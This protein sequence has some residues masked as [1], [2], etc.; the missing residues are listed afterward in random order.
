MRYI[1]VLGL[2]FSLSFVSAIVQGSAAEPLS[3]DTPV[4]TAAGAT[5]TAPA[6]CSITSSANKNVLDPPEAD[7]PARMDV[8]YSVVPI[9]RAGGMWT[10]PRDLPK[11]KQME[12]AL[13]QL[14]DGRQ[15]VSEENLLERAK[16]QVQ[17]TADTTY[18]M[19][20]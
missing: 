13:G 1:N 4:T 17:T 18:G 6:G 7:S 16:G 11:Y 2:A 10:S 20:S 8:N 9:R 3:A 12:L 19:G 5:F 15:L 14:P